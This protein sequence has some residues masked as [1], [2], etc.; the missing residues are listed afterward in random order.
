MTTQRELIEVRT[1]TN[2]PTG[3]ELVSFE[4]YPFMHEATSLLVAI[5]YAIRQAY[6]PTYVDC[7]GTYAISYHKPNGVQVTM[8]IVPPQ[9]EYEV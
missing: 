4:S 2:M 5:C 6:G 3:D 1:V 7:Q 8:T 9:P